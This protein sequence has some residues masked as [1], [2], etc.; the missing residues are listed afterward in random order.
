M[1]ALLSNRSIA[2]RL[3]LGV[4]L[5]AGFVLGL[6]VWFNYRT[7]RA[8]LERQT[9]AKALSEIR[10]A[11]H[12]V[13]DF[14]ARIGMLPRSTASC[15]QLYGRDPDPGMVPLM[16]QL[17]AQVPED[18]VYG[19][20]MAFEDK[21][22]RE[23]DSMPWVDRKSW[24]NKT[25]VGYDYHAPDQEWYAATK[26]TGTVRVTEPYYDEGGSGI[27]MVTYAVPMFDAASKFIG[28]ATADLAL[29]RIRA[30]VRAARLR[31][32]AESGRAGTHEYA[33]L[34]SR[35]GKIIVHPDEGLMVRRGYP[36][37]DLAS[38][39]GGEFIAA[40]PEGFA[41]VRMDGERRRLYW[42]TSPLTGWKAVLNI[43][44]DEIL[45]PVRELTIRSALIGVA[46]LVAL[47]VVV[48]LIA[49]RLAT[50]LLNLTHTAAAIEH[51]NF[52][53]EMLGALPQRRDEIGEL[54]RSFQKMEREIRSRE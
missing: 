28:V 10:A 39:P 8:E 7:S 21:D 27:T 14:I 42:S 1:K 32:A 49:R 22:W 50:P 6:T 36:G 52:R 37:A 47:I 15:Q 29:D 3:Q 46:G 4:G 18:E 54:S 5:A 2:R 45:I 33:F 16:A 26:S 30:M 48:S 43:S 51:G 17:L 35:A 12:R 38:R 40:K 19:L 13:D 23:E 34:V 41:A 24:P 9:N 20:A 53:A 31:G 25:R 44:E 11:A